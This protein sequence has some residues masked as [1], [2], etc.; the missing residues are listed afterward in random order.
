MGRATIASP[1]LILFSSSLTPSQTH[2]ETESLI[3][4]ILV[5]ILSGDAGRTFLPVNFSAFI[6][7]LYEL[8]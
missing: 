1:F 6:P 3:A 4:F 5:F 7:N 2:D 8:A